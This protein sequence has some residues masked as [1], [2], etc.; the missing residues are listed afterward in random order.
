[1]KVF[2]FPGQ[3]SQSIG[4][5]EGLFEK[6]PKIVEQANEI[7]GYDIQDLCLKDSK[8]QLGQTEF[9]QPVLYTVNYLHFLD[10]G[11]EADVY[12]GH[13]LGE[14]NALLAAGAFNFLTGLKLVQKRGELMSQATGGAMA[15]VLG[16]VREDIFRILE[17]NNLN[18]IDVA[19]FNAPIQTVLSGKEADIVDVQKK[20]INSGAKRYIKLAVSGAFHSRYMKPASEQFSGFAQQFSFS[21]PKKRVISNVTADNYQVDILDLL[22]KQIYSS[23]EWVETIRTIKAEGTEFI[24]LGPGKVLTGLYRKIS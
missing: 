14:Y 3:G 20:F 7:L 4:M 22:V 2:A 8:S 17:E 24:E 1:M 19:N 10:Y 11:Q 6:F 18:S 5:G 16:L 21:K 9:T 15:A 12:L 23:V 13:S